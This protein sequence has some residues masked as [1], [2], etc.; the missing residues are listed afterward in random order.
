MISSN[1]MVWYL[2]QNRELPDIGPPCFNMPGK[3]NESILQMTLACAKGHERKKE[4]ERS[5]KNDEVLRSFIKL[6]SNW[7][8]IVVRPD[9]CLWQF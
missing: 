5:P 9:F 6:D 7:N 1:L 8:A 2:L 3:K 4:N